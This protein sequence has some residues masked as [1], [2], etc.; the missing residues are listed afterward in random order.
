MSLHL[1]GVWQSGIGTEIVHA[2]LTFDA[3]VSTATQLLKQDLR[4]VSADVN[5]GSYAGV[6]RPGTSAEYIFSGSVADAAALDKGYFAQGLRLISLSVHDQGVLCVWRPGAGAQHWSV[7]LTLKDLKALD[8]TYFSQGFH[9]VCV[10]ELDGHFAAVWQPG[11][12]VQYWT[13]GSD[14]QIVAADKVHFAAGLQIKAIGGHQGPLIVVWRSQT[15]GQLWSI[16][17]PLVSLKPTD[18]ANVAKGLRMSA[19]RVLADPSAVDPG[20]GAWSLVDDQEIDNQEW[21]EECQGLASNG[22]SWFVASNN[23]DFKGVHRLSLGLDAES[24]KIQLPAG[25]ADHVGAPCIE[26]TAGLIYVPLEG[27]VG[28]WIVNQQLQTVAVVPA[29]QISSAQG[30][31]MSWC[32]VNPWDGF[33]YSSTFDGVDRIHAYD[34]ATSFEHVRTLILTGPPLGNVQGGCFSSNGHLYLTSDTSGRVYGFDIMSGESLGSIAV[35]YSPGGLDGEELEGIAIAHL[36]DANGAKSL[37]HVMVLDND[38]TNEDDV[39]M[40]HYGLPHPENV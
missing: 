14:D 37:V 29:P 4:L 3:F 25:A 26:P 28:I 16:G 38:I 8:A 2:A 40:K 20:M 1:T 24:G 34:P 15:G 18:D 23:S 10:D 27:P 33:L 13:Y 32:A 9:M 31:H 12:G 11:T 36:V 22:S 21:T 30:G 6:W 5:R 39:F 7:G 19:I 35:P 17:V